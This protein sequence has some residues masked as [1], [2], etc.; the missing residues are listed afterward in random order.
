MSPLKKNLCPIDFSEPPFEELEEF[1]S[2]HELG[3]SI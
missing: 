1:L 2:A 3:H